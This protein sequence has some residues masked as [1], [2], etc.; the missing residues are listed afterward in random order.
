MGF[1][2]DNPPSDTTLW[3]GI[4][5][6]DD[7]VIEEAARRADNAFLHVQLPSGRSLE[8]IGTNPEKPQF[9]YEIT[10]Y[11]REISTERRMRKVTDIVA[12]YMTL[13]VP[14]ISFDR[15]PDGPNYKY[16]PESFYRLLAHIALEDCYTENG[17]EM[18]RWLTGD[19]V[20]IPDPTTLHKHARKYDVD[21][22]AERFLN[23]TQAVLKRDGLLPPEPVHLGF[24]I[25]KVPWYGRVDT[26]EDVSP[27]DEEWRIKTE[28]KDNTTWVWAVAVLSIVTPDRNTSSAS[29][30]S[31]QLTNTI[32]PWT[33]CLSAP[34]TGSTSSL[35][36]STSI[37]GWETPR[38]WTS[39]KSTA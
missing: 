26:D 23:A 39:A 10:K 7:N 2:P 8:T 25:T 24:D 4:R 21:E 29:S 1:D 22:H 34:K 15:D 27:T 3:R 32:T 36:V 13:A 30:R 31:V 16:T 35:A 17:S 9:Y 20:D 33:P 28:V 38:S 12:E 11:D 37:A 18:L 6:L 5:D 14:S 19:D